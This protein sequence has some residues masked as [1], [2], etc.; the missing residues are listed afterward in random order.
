MQ[1]IRYR[2]TIAK[3]NSGQPTTANTKCA[4]YCQ[5]EDSDV[6]DQKAAPCSSQMPS[7]VTYTVRFGWLE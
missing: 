2:R 5:S 7:T 1:L 3:E 6:K 4:V